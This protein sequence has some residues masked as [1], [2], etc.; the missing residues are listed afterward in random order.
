[1]TEA[2][3]IESIDARFPYGDEGE[4]RRLIDEGAAISPNAAFMTLHE[5]CRPPRSTRMPES[6][7]YRMLEYWMGRV[8]H[9]LADPVAKL[10]KAMIEQRDL[11][12][13]DA[14]AVMEEVRQFPGEYNA[15]AIVYFSCD[16]VEGV[17]D[18]LYQQIVREWESS[19]SRFDTDADLPTK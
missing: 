19:N 9:P 4:W 7:Q 10:A 5:I 8:K 3:F 13:E 6:A 15:L 14:V 16:D 2:E 11:P 17:A 1:M 12:V 18:S